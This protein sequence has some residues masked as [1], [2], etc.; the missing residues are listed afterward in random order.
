M[1]LKI[2]KNKPYLIIG[3]HAAFYCD[4][5][6]NKTLIL[7]SP[8][9]LS[10]LKT[11]SVP[12]SINVYT[13]LPG[14]SYNHYDFPK[15][16]RFEV[17][18]ALK[19]HPDLQDKKFIAASAIITKNKSIN[20]WRLTSTPLLQGWLKALADQTILVKSL[21]PLSFQ[22][23]FSLPEVG[24]TALYRVS[25]TTDHRARHVCLIKGVIVFVRYTALD[26]TARDEIKETLHFIQRDYAVDSSDITTLNDLDKEPTLPEGKPQKSLNLLWLD[27]FPETL[28]LSFKALRKKQQHQKI[29]TIFKNASLC[30]AL[31][32]GAFLLKNGFSYYKAHTREK[33]LIQLAKTLPQELQNLPLTSLESI[34][35]AAEN[36]QTPDFIIAALQGQPE[37]NFLLEEFHW[38]SLGAARQQ[39]NIAVRRQGTFTPEEEAAY[40]ES[41]FNETPKILPFDQ[42]VDRFEVVLT[43]DL[44]RKEAP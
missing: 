32:S 36:S 17:K 37:P 4:V 35:F 34:L 43:Q 7:K 22:T 44:N 28:C 18:Q 26:H 1:P 2:F 39:L 20:L 6:R 14:A 29:A 11:P 24:T 21:I 27:R 38:R 40:L 25:K 23:A 15:L 5:A 10:Q 9:D 31:L 19:N 42:Y 41:L 13:D 12:S 3:E 33:A 30:A 16:S 8:Q